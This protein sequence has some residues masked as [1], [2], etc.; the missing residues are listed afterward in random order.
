M[1]DEP[2]KRTSDAAKQFFYGENGVYFLLIFTTNTKMVFACPGTC[3]PPLLPPNPKVKGQGLRR[4]ATVQRFPN[5]PKWTQI[6]FIILP[7]FARFT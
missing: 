1:P 5:L 3:I 7:F 2:F 4:V 6:A